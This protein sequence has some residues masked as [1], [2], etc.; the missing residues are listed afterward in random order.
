[1]LNSDLFADIKNAFLD[2]MD[3]QDNEGNNVSD[4]ALL[5]LNRAQDNLE[6]YDAWDLLVKDYSLTLGGADGRT[7]SFP[8]D[9]GEI[10]AV[11]SDSNGDGKIDWNFYREGDYSNGYKIRNSF[12]RI[13]GHSLSITFFVTPQSTPILKYKSKIPDLLGQENELSFF[14][15]D[16]LLLEAQYIHITESGLVGND[17]QAILNRR[18]EIL[19]DY[20]QEHQYKNNDMRIVNRDSRGCIVTNPN[21]SMTGEMDQLRDGL[22]NDTDRSFD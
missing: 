14:P 6:R 15:F 7:A 1:M 11:G 21:Y 9:F 4:V 12:D 19:R 22:T 2:W 3:D 13:T 8:S 5:T 16:L 18:R 10:I 20:R 17:Y